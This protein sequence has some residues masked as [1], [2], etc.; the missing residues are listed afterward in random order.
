MNRLVSAVKYFNTSGAALILVSGG[1]V[2]PN[3]TPFNE[4]FQ[5]RHLLLREFGISPL[6]II[7]DP[8]V[9]CCHSSS[10]YPI[11]YLLLPNDYKS[12]FVDC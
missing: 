2:H 1:N 7:I 4:A 3:H 12:R 5:M 9:T 10:I 6:Q 8:Y 11:F